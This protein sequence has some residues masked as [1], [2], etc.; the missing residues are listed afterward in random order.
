MLV[1]QLLVCLGFD[2]NEALGQYIPPLAHLQIMPDQWPLCLAKMM[3]EFRRLTLTF[4]VSRKYLPG[5]PKR[6]TA[7]YLKKER[8]FASE[9]SPVI[10]LRVTPNKAFI[11]GN[12]MTAES[13][14]FELML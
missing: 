12:M 10:S 1:L 14:S 13:T 2:Q 4:L 9:Q 7:A 11:S 3:Q 6:T 8:P 5:S